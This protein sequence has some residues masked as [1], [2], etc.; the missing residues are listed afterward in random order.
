MDEEMKPSVYCLNFR[1]PS[2]GGLGAGL[3]KEKA[4]LHGE[5]FFF[6]LCI[7][8]ALPLPSSLHPLPSVIPPPPLEQLPP[9]DPVR[10]RV[11]EEEKLGGEVMGV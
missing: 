4:L 8:N 6:L 5:S 7:S 9:W 3:E 10:R 2:V 1:L 11:E